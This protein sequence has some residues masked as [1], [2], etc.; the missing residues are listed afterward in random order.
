MSERMIVIPVVFSGASSADARSV[1][2]PAD[3]V[4]V[5]ADVMTDAVTGSPT[6]ASVAVQDD[7][8]AVSGFSP[9]TPGVTVGGGATAWSVHLG[10]VIEPAAMARGSKVKAIITLT[11][12]TTPTW[13]GSLR[14]YC[15]V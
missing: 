8:V 15:L 6:G 11:G 3:V 12:G 7:G 2:L 1:I 9:I 13:T 5:G 4:L 14:L 10:G